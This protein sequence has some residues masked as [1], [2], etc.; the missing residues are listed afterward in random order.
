M[1]RDED[2]AIDDDRTMRDYEPPPS[3]ARS[4]PLL[5]YKLMVASILHD[6]KLKIPGKVIK[7]IE[8]ELSIVVT[9]SVPDGR[10]WNMKLGK[11]GG[12][13]WFGDGWVEFMNYY[14]VRVGYLLIFRYKGDST[15][16]VNVFNLSNAEIQ[17]SPDSVDS[18]EKVIE[19]KQC[20]ES[21]EVEE[22]KQWMLSKKLASMQVN[23]DTLCS[24][25]KDKEFGNDNYEK[26][27]GSE[28]IRQDNQCSV[29]KGKE[30]G[31]D[32]TQKKSDSEKAE[33][34]KICLVT[35]DKKSAN[36]DDKKKSELPPPGCTFKSSPHSTGVEKEMKP[37]G[38]AGSQGSFLLVKDVTPGNYR[39]SVMSC[40][41]TKKP[42]VRKVKNLQP[43]NQENDHLGFVADG[44][45]SNSP[46]KE[47]T[48]SSKMAVNVPQA[49]RVSS[50]A[51]SEGS[52]ISHM[53]SIAVEV[54]VKLPEAEKLTSES[55]LPKYVTDLPPGG[56]VVDSPFKVSKKDQLGTRLI[57]AEVDVEL[58]RKKELIS[59][60]STSHAVR[61]TPVKRKMEINT[62][63]LRTMTTAVSV[64][65]KEDASTADVPN[66]TTEKT[67]TVQKKQKT[68][69][70][71]TIS[72]TPG[73]P[74]CV[75]HVRASHV[76][77]KGLLHMP[78][79]FAS[80]YLKGTSG[81]ATLQNLEG[82]QWK[83]RLL[84]SHANIKLSKGWHQFATD[85]FLKEGDICIFEL[86]DSLNTLL[87]VTFIRYRK[88]HPT[89][90]Q[91][92]LRL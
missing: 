48:H 12:K 4:R 36:E 49:N 67:A 9:L 40:K 61:C 76:K 32:V 22:D 59:A 57:A 11:D 10:K 38:A 54:D 24:A 37:S 35:K 7:R 27:S 34:D 43:K 1:G 81:Y 47:D 5:F 68:V 86:L 44:E 78:A 56:K 64:E 50:A 39:A 63:N 88:D 41:K 14:S 66:Y 18:S 31:N 71:S 3:S 46:D 51:K 69:Q 21:T 45:N 75:V 58:Q 6:N 73:N 33:E 42:R 89:A 84:P 87:K 15:F 13:C 74:Y 91:E 29:N 17:Y 52:V 72:N 65:H 8:Q 26:S 60:N 20:L 85:N 28:E 77:K 82:K 23:E 70:L 92:V 19:E 16:V 2:E 55:E 90:D 83:V 79:I 25:T 62:A 30:S 80:K 53:G